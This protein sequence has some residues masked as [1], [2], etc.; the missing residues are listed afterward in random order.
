MADYKLGYLNI[1]TCQIEECF[2]DHCQ[3]MDYVS[4]I[5]TE[6]FL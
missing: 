6:K 5:M 3:P 4:E 1:I 2:H